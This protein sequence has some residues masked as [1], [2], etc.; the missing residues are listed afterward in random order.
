MY[1]VRRC[2]YFPTAS[3]QEFFQSSVVSWVGVLFC[4]AGLF[5]LFLSLVSFGKSFWVG[6]DPDHPDNLVTTGVFAFSRNSVYVAFAGPILSVLKLDSFGLH[7]CWRM[8][9]S[10]PGLA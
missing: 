5:L 6:I 4:L 2:I 7:R 1:R 8:A 9:I 10:P 3:R